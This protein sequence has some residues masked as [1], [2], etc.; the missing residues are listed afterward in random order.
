MGKRFSPTIEDYLEA[1]GQLCAAGGHARGCD[2][3]VRLS[4]HKSTVTA[5]LRRL[6][7]EG[8]VNYSPYGETTLTA[9][10]DRVAREVRRRHEAIRRFLSRV[11]QLDPAAADTA[12]C[13]LEHAMDREIVLRLGRLTAFLESRD[14]LGGDLYRELE[15]MP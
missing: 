3:A 6:A 7:A 4:V 12:A 9:A 10:G 11:L 8:L 5:M 14:L 1:V 13:R 2:L 15:G